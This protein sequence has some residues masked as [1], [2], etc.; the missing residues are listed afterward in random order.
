[1]DVLAAGLASQRLLL[2]YSDRWSGDVA[3]KAS[4]AGVIV[5]TPRGGRITAPIEQVIGWAG[6]DR[7]EAP[8][9]V[10]ANGVPVPIAVVPRPELIEARIPHFGFSIF[11]DL[12]A[13]HETAP[14]GPGPMRLDFIC[15]GRPIAATQLTVESAAVANLQNLLRERRVRREFIVKSTA[16]RIRRVP[17]C[18]A[19]SALPPGWLL[20]PDVRSKIDA[21]S[22]HNYGATVLNFIE[23]LE[24]DGFI[25][26]A[27]AG[28]RRVPH[29][30]V[31]A[32]EIYDYPSTDILA[33]GQNLPF[34][35]NTFAGA[36]SVAV[37]EHVD[38]P[39]VCAK[40]LLR[41]VRPGGKILCVI[42][43]L[44]AEHGY[45]SHYFNAT[46]FG[47][48]KLFEDAKLERQWLE[49]SNHPVFT[50]H[51]ILGLYAAGLPEPQR[52][53][54]L[55]TPTRHFV[56]TMPVDLYLQNHPFVTEL[57]PSAQWA[58][59]WGTTS[60]FTKG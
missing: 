39:F 13:I 47:V 54:F 1:M 36:I 37:L 8:L 29:A 3:V 49:I 11:L 28:L 26:D 41:V 34:D 16:G 22:A 43:F 59:A 17:G 23:S 35:D 52:Q 45:P 2:A 25:L 14:V 24:K 40:E 5:D 57:R 30:R 56:E 55:D 27:G 53:R 58:L 38:D 4:T 60:V 31:I 48:R 18:S 44:Q 19:Y 12:I 7:G 50:L 21:A 33:V 46:R 15:N 51:Q 9:E 32:M 42:P 10:T 20:S 6:A